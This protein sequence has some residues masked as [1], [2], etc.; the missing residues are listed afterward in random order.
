MRSRLL[1]R[2]VD[3]PHVTSPLWGPPR[4][5]KQALRML[6]VTPQDSWHSRALHF[7]QVLGIFVVFH[8]D[9]LWWNVQL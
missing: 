9:G 7:I 3:P 4:P 8:R 1:D 5:Y 6:F 2:W